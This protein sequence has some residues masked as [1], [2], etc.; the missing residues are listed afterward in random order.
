VGLWSRIKGVF[1]AAPSE[2]PPPETHTTIEPPVAIAEADEPEDE[3]E[4]EDEEDD[5]LAY[6]APVARDRDL[7]AAIEADPDGIEPYLV[8]ADWL[9]ERGDPRGELI[10]TQHA[11]RTTKDAAEHAELAEREDELLTEHRNYLEGPADQY[12]FDIV[13]W[14]LGFAR[15]LAI[16]DREGL[17]KLRRVLAAD[18]PALRF[19]R[20]IAV[21]SGD[22]TKATEIV[23]A[24]G[25]ALEVVDDDDRTFDPD[26]V[27][28][29]AASIEIEEVDG[30]A[31]LTVTIDDAPFSTAAGYSYL[32]RTTFGVDVW[33]HGSGDALTEE[34]MC[35]DPMRSGTTEVGTLGEPRELHMELRARLPDDDTTH[36]LWFSGRAS[37]DR[38]G[39]KLLLVRCEPRTGAPFDVPQ[40]ATASPR[41]GPAL[42]SGEP[43]VFA[44]R[45]NAA[46]PGLGIYDDAS[47]A[48]VTE[49]ARIA[50]TN[51]P[52]GNCHG[53]A[54]YG[55]GNGALVVVHG[56][57]GGGFRSWVTT[58]R[59]GKRLAQVEVAGS[60]YGGAVDA[61]G[62]WFG[63]LLVHA[64]GSQFFVFD[65]E[66]GKQLGECPVPPSEL[67]GH[68]VQWDGEKV[69]VV[70]D[71]RVSCF[72]VATGASSV[73]AVPKMIGVGWRQYGA[74]APTYHAGLA[75]TA[76]MICA[77]FPDA[78]VDDKTG[79]TLIGWRDRGGPNRFAAVPDHGWSSRDSFATV[80]ILDDGRIVGIGTRVW[81]VDPETRIATDYGAAGV[82]PA[83]PLVATVDGRVRLYAQGPGPSWIEL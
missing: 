40:P 32:A 83:T 5:A 23:E 37:V 8:Y 55:G 69:H 28:N 4:D 68:G 13:D 20:R 61:S 51:D 7:E 34:I 30:V 46:L 2:P 17:E 42:L 57:R 66:T 29:V 77:E 14:H 1:A 11:R 52:P 24:L 3:D 67:T 35:D 60:I 72:D 63:A 45:Q 79:T 49:G 59:V 58:S 78:T 41:V 16:H 80:R 48:I 27:P 47:G 43:A 76:W 44:N 54:A 53:E 9:Q 38:E 75:R 26:D 62:R 73:F 25:R 12:G 74:G 15:T 65:I 81:V 82:Y 33:A 10:T 70:G 18:H 71:G 31:E 36:T 22:V 50:V 56:K 64:K 39:G 6:A 21:S 19:L